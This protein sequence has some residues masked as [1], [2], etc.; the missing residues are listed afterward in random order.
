[1][2]T[3]KSLEQLLQEKI[4]SQNTYDKVVLSKQYIERKYNAKSKKNLELI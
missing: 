1:M 4:I 2:M 3:K